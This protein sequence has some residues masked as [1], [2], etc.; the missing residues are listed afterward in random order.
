M[1]EY[2]G[3]LIILI[4]ANLIALLIVGLSYFLGER[5]PK[6]VK[7]EPYECGMTTIGPARRRISIKYYIFA[8]LFL[9][10]DIEVLFMYPWAVVTKN[11]K[12]FGFIEMF[13]FIIILLVGYVY[14]WKKGALEWE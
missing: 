6:K 9:I 13:I 2:I 1:K 8:M 14:V 7:L 3:I 10:F 5:K 11:L 4:F 12:L